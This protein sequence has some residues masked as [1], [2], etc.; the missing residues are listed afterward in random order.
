[1]GDAPAVAPAQGAPADAQA[2]DTGQDAEASTSARATDVKV[3]QADR[4]IVYTGELTVRAKDVTAAADTA[5]GIVTEAGG[6]L[7]R[8]QATSV[9]GR[10]DAT[11]VFKIPPDRYPSVV[12]RLGKELGKRESLNLGTEDV[13]EEIADVDSRVKS[14]KAGLAQ[15]RTFLKR[16]GDIKE[17][18]QVEREISTREAD[19][20]ALQARQRSLATQ[21]ASGTLTLHLVNTP[22]PAPV[23]KKPKPQPANFLS[24]LKTGWNALTTTVRVSLAIFGALLPWLVV[25]AVLWLAYVLLRRRVPSLVGQGRAGRA[26][27]PAPEPEP[28]PEPAE[29]P[30]ATEPVRPGERAGAAPR[31]EATDVPVWR[32]TVEGPQPG[33]PRAP[34]EPGASGRPG[35]SDERGE[36]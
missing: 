10:D 12:D 3:R 33:G 22:P 20:E 11:L 24:G 13:T 4:A 17:V 15:V 35:A 32:G 5:K 27:P 29:I 6:R 34:G 23:V 30:Y 16:A 31:V 18:L 8:E 9:G 36:H 2:G 14:A 19:L 1:M 25:L 26:A 21:T 7:D 28:R